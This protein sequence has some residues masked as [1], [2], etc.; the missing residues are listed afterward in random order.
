MSR[1]ER[2]FE[3]LVERPSARLF[4]TRLQPLQILRRIERAM[5]ADRG[6]EGHR[7]LVPDQFTVR[8][9][10]ED[11]AALLPADEV[12]TELASGALSFARSHGYALR[13]RPR[14]ILRPDPRRRPGEVEIETAVSAEAE[15][16]PVAPGIDSGTRVFEVPV[17]RAPAVVLQIHEPGK[18]ARRIPMS[19]AQMGIGRAPECDLVLKDSRA[20]R[21]HARLAARDGVL[22]LT[23]LGSTNGTRV[24]GHRVTEVVLGA[25]DRVQIGETSL[26]VESAGA[27]ADARP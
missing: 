5:E 4:G 12:A 26:V 21:R 10:P 13:E 16:I 20:S 18:A 2:F 24:N 14:V 8:L 3:R 19:G 15:A 6:A 7:G 25:G 17:V 9:H 1:V 27:G 23:D 22:V 11:L